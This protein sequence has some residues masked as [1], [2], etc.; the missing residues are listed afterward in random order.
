MSTFGVGDALDLIS[1]AIKVV[2]VINGALADVRNAPEEIQL[3]RDRLA[4]LDVFLQDLQHRRE[5]GHLRSPQDLALLE[6]LRLRAHKCVDDIGE[7]VEK[8]LRVTKDGEQKIDAFKW[9]TRR[10]KLEELSKK[11]DDL[12]VALC[13]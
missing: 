7:F 13:C 3:L 12:E 2:K 9:I 6:R 11:L 8:S 10:S 5:E 1:R 4:Y